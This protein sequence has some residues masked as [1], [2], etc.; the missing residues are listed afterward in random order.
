MAPP[1]SCICRSD[2]ISNTFVQ[3][4]L[5][6]MLYYQVR[7][8]I[9]K[10]SLTLERRLK[11]S[12]TVAHP[13]VDTQF[14]VFHL[15]LWFKIR[16]DLAWHGHLSSEGALPILTIFFGHFTNQHQPLHD[17]ATPAC[18]PSAS[19]QRFTSFPSKPIHNEESIVPFL[20]P[21]VSLSPSPSLLS[22]TLVLRFLPPLFIHHDLKNISVHTVFPSGCTAV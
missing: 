3:I 1:P 5:I 20:L 9:G 7:R 6:F 16:Q 10:S 21:S 14:W 13:A 18:S 22:T 11:A 4:P 19:P 12:E 15:L 2:R 17:P 8:E